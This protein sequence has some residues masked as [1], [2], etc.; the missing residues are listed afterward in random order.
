[1]QAHHICPRRIVSKIPVRWNAGA[2][3]AERFDSVPDARPAMPAI[4]RVTAKP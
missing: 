4:G 3:A 2:K 1:L